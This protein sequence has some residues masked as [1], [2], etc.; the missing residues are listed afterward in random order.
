MTRGLSDE[1]YVH[2]K[3]IPLRWQFGQN[4]AL[5]WYE[6]CSPAH[7]VVLSLPPCCKEMLFMKTKIV[8]LGRR[9]RS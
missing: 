1:Q 9:W 5:L 2:S 4:K 7:D 8:W 6:V 3:F